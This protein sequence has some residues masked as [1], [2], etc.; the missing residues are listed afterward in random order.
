MHVVSLQNFIIF[1][2]LLHIQRKNY[3]EKFCHKM[4][5]IFREMVVFVG[6]IFLT[7]AVFVGSAVAAASHLMLVL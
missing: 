4:F 7:V 2:K 6:W 3:C 1:V 5:S